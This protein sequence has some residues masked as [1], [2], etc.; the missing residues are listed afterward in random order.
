M[1][2]PWILPFVAGCTG[3]G[4]LPDLSLTDRN[5]ERACPALETGPEGPFATTGGS[6]DRAPCTSGAH[7]IGGAAGQWL[8][9]DLTTWSGTDSARLT[10]RDWNGTL[11]HEASG[12]RAGETVGFAV[13][14]SGEQLL[15]LVPEGGTDAGGTYA[16][17]VRCVADCNAEWSRYPFLVMHGFGSSGASFED[18]V[19]AV[20]GA[21]YVA[22][23]PSVSKFDASDVRAAQWSAHLDAW[24]AEGTWRG[25][26]LIGHSLGGMDARYLA[27]N[28]D[29]GRRVKTITTLSTPHWGTPVAD[30]ALGLVDH[31]YTPSE[32]GEMVEAMAPEGG[33]TGPDGL[34]AIGSPGLANA[35]YQLSQP[36][37][38]YFNQTV[39]DRDDVIYRSWTGMT[40]SKLDLFCQWDWDFEIVALVLSPT[41]VVMK[42]EGLPSD[43]VVSVWS[44]IWGDFGGVLAADHFEMGGGRP[45]AWPSF[46]DDG[47]FAREADRL[48]ALE[49]GVILEGE[50]Q[51]RTLEE[52]LELDW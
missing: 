28:L 29:P 35:L 24:Q 42:A 10:L 46:D 47:F 26:H 34:V 50:A 48:A 32:I 22:W 21:G 2:M 40:C 19:A 13:P 4:L 49:R 15:E 52:M 16:F 39:P 25:V 3:S 9:L 18:L 36:G 5:Q 33:A 8:E 14:W 27:A 20:E 30:L 43:G 45:F 31:D 12:L 37:A 23:A 6:G 11:L 17:D 41:L 38:L 7:A 44:G 51:A 1:R